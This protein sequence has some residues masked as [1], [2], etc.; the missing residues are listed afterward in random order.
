MAN[1]TYTFIIGTTDDFDSIEDLIDHFEGSNYPDS[2]CNCAAYEF[3][4]PADL[5]EDTVTLI[6]RGLAFSNDWCMD[7][8]FSF[9][10]KGPLDG[11]AEKDMFQRGVEARDAQKT[12]RSEQQNHDLWNSNDPLNW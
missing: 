7:D 5:D 6:G 1:K 10:V 3:E 11:P 4:A 12:E 9:L 8:T 2:I